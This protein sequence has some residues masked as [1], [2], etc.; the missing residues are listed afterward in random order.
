M[1][2]QTERHLT[3]AATHLGAGAE[4][5]SNLR[6]EIVDEAQAGLAAAERSVR[7]QRLGRSRGERLAAAQERPHA[8]LNPVEAGKRDLGH[9]AL[10]R[11]DGL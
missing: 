11:D 5:R 1:K 6:G 3:A 8:E 7:R 4:S 9:G 2:T 10:Q